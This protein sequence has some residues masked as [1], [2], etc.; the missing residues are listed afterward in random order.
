MCIR[1]SYIAEL[2]F[3]QNSRKNLQYKL[4]D[5]KSPSPHVWTIILHFFVG[6]HNDTTMK[7]LLWIWSIHAQVLN[8]KWFLF[9]KLLFCLGKSERAEWDLQFRCHQGTNIVGKHLKTGLTSSRWCFIVRFTWGSARSFSDGW[10]TGRNSSSELRSF[11]I[12]FHDIVPCTGTVPATSN[13]GHTWS[14]LI[15]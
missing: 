12:D 4:L 11:K 7:R 14:S 10:Y 8:L 9:A 13:S 3:G 5:R 6:F 2:F 15:P 1:D